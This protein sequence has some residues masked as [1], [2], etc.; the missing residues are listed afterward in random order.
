MCISTFFVAIHLDVVGGMICLAA[1]NCLYNTFNACNFILFLVTKLDPSF[2]C[3]LNAEF[4]LKPIGILWHIFLCLHMMILL[5]L[6]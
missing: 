4:I 2:L 6:A 3:S 1:P 5:G